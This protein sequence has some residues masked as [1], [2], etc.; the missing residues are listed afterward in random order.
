MKQLA[1]S[2]FAAMVTLSA[3]SQ[4][5][6]SDKQREEVEQIARKAALNGAD[7][8]LGDRMSDAE[9]RADDAEAR[10]DDIEAKLRM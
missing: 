6:L 4:P 10:L 3:C 9:T 2:F 5:G 8:Q 7:D 1:A